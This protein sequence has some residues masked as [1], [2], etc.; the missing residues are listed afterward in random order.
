MEF[1]DAFLPSEDE[2]EDLFGANEVEDL[3]E[4]SDSG[5]D[6]NEVELVPPG[7]AS[8]ESSATMASATPQ[9]MERKRKAADAEQGQKDAT[10]RL[11]RLTT[12]PKPESPVARP[13]LCITGYPLKQ[14]VPVCPVKVDG[15]GKQWVIL[16]F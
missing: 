12:E 3:L 9:K 10:R 13:M 6:A 8:A 11:M 1:R 2:D 4:V 5:S 7:G 15:N 16:S 14:P